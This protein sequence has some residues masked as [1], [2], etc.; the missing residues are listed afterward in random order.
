MNLE[1]DHQNI[2]SSFDRIA[3]TLL[4]EKELH[5]NNHI[6]QLTE[7]EF[8]YFHPDHHPDEY[9]HPHKRE[10]G[11]WRFHNSGIDIT[12]EG[13]DKK[14]GGILIRGIAINGEY[15]N[16]SRKILMRIFEAFGRVSEP[17]TFVLKDCK[18]RN[19][20][21]V[22]TFRHLPNKITYP[23]FH[24]QPYRYIADIEKLKLPQALK[25]EIVENGIYL[26]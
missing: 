24:S 5:V 15:I 7:I 22:K 23:D 14:D 4:N 12:F 1:I 2:P 9:T 20:Q 21:I 8:Y 6:F 19:S 17:T 16:G 13:D 18:P 3:Q 25:A 26:V 11:E 10:A